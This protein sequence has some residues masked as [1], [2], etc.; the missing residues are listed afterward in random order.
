VRYLNVVERDGR[1]ESRLAER[2]DPVPGPGE[3][4]VRV[5][6]SGVNRA[7]LSQAAGRYPAP[8][9]E[10]EILGLEVSGWLVDSGAAV[11]ALLG[12]GGHAELVAVPRGQTFPAPAGIDLVPAA[13]IPEAYLTAFLHLVVMGKLEAG[14]RALI[15]AGASGVG[16]AAIQLAKMVGAHVAATTRTSQKVGA[17]R[18]A[19]ADVAIDTSRADPA[20]EIVRHWGPDS[21]QVVLDPV[22][23]TTLGGD[24][25]VLAT[26]GQIVCIATMGGSHADLDISRL[27]KKRAGVVGSTLRARGRAEKA[28]LVERFQHEVLPGFER[29]RLRVIVDTVVPPELASEAFQRLHENRNVGKVLI[30]WMG[31]GSIS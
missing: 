15:H 2:A 19:G 12:G 6:A 22:G 31:A 17:L 8:P 21:V 18:A 20:A 28:G 27:M 5:A 26:G 25:D 4:L 13:G 16:L 11:C 9:G 14:Q 29:G 7:D 1:Y 3:V 10:S 23:A 30:D 24:L